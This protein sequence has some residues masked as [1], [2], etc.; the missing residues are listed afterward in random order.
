MN[1]NEYLEEKIEFYRQEI[2]RYK[3]MI[4]YE[5][6]DATRKEFLEDELEVAEEM[7]EMF[8]NIN[9]QVIAWDAIKDSIT[10]PAQGT[11]EINNTFT[12]HTQMIEDESKYHKILEALQYDPEINLKKVLGWNEAKP[13]LYMYL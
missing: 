13:Y 11:F 10:A 4:L 5:K 6:E 8:V 1:K 7:F 3:N 9:T 12:S 2:E